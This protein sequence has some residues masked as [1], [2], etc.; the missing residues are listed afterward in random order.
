MDKAQQ[1]GGRWP[2]GAYGLVHGLDGQ[3]AEPDWPPLV[4]DELRALAQH[5]CALRGPIEVL[6]RSPRPFSAAARVQTERGEVFVK[7]HDV[8]V[9]DVQALREEHRFIAHLQA[10][11]MPVP[12]VL[13]ADGGED[14]Q[15]NAAGGGDVRPDPTAVTAITIG[16]WTY[17]VHALAPGVDAYRD[18]HSWVPARSGAHAQ[19]LGRALA[20]LHLAAQGYEAPARAVRP[21]IGGFGIIGA[22]PLDVALAR[23]LALRPALSAFLDEY[24]LRV[25]GDAR[26]EPDVERGDRDGILATLGPWH[27]ALAPLL[28][29]LPALWVH[30][31]WHASNVFWTDRSDQAQVR[32]V[33]DF[34]LCNLGCAVA[35]LAT[36][37]ER[38]TIAWLDL[39]P[40][41]PASAEAAGET[42]PDIGRVPLAIAL[43]EG[44]TSV[45]AL[46]VAE[47]HALPVLMGLAHVEF[48][49]S[50]AD[51]FYGIIGNPA[52]ARLA[53]PGFLVGHVRWFESRHG[54]DYLAAVRGALARRGG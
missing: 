10:R 36:A 31:D 30:N 22:N 2:G 33:I 7:R 38:N 53:C 48:A 9:R 24:G 41:P 47:R 51:Y 27:A 20:Q 44:Y 43:L 35:D 5:H 34:G 50:E 12:R 21:L 14:A 1:S 13:A 19:A 37:L 11:G 54:R 40:G 15:A 6:W 25:S 52:N 49:L 39:P 3:A 29:E 28:P 26:P 4:V 8:R 23:Y 32:A 18:T 45:R 17:E 42:V 46:S 16:R